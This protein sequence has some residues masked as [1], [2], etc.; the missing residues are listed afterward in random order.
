MNISISVTERWYCSSC[1][2]DAARMIQAGDEELYLCTP[3]LKALAS[4]I[5]PPR[6]RHSKL[7]LKAK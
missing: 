7:G 5:K 4:L 6:T 2:S 3:C 1:R